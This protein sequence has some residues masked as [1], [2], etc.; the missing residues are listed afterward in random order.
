LY[1]ERFDVFFDKYK[2]CQKNDKCWIDLAL[3][4]YPP[5]GTLDLKV[6]T[7]YFISIPT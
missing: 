3:L 7:V 5:V 2:I 4:E 1:F 6:D